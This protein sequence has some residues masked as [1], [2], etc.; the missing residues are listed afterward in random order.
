M[1]FTTSLAVQLR[2]T[3]DTANSP[4]HERGLW[5]NTLMRLKA[6]G[7]DE[8]TIAVGLT[9]L[10]VEPVLT[11]DPIAARRTSVIVKHRAICLLL[12]KKENPILTP[13]ERQQNRDEI[14]GLLELRWR[15]GNIILSGK[16]EAAPSAGTSSTT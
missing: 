15:T 10:H 7:Y 12:V 13:T 14:K 3:M 5:G 1:T 6:E 2:R 8:S 9:A 4:S 11:A 16:A